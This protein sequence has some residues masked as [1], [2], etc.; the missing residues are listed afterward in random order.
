[1][2]EMV[3][4]STIIASLVIALGSLGIAS[5]HRGPARADPLKQPRET[6]RRSRPVAIALGLQ[7][8]GTAAWTLQP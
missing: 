7:G 3:F 1:M 2:I 4:L 5:T 6:Y 8:L